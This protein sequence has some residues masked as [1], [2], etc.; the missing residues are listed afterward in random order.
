MRACA[1]TCV[2]LH[3]PASGYAYILHV[4]MYISTCIGMLYVC[5]SVS[6]HVLLCM[7]MCIHVIL[8][9]NVIICVLVYMCVC[10]CVYMIIHVLVYSKYM[11]LCVCTCVSMY[12]FLLVYV[13]VGGGWWLR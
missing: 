13:Y 1:C 3:V 4:S 6:M 11:C 8:I 12:V 10:A 5:M 2:F 9:W 7:H